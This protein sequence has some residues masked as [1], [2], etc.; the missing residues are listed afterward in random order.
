MAAPTPEQIQYQLQHIQDD[1]SDEIITALGICLAFAII[2]VLLR[3]VARHLT[4]APL[5]ADDWTILF[6]LVRSKPRCFHEQLPLFAGSLAEMRFSDLRHW[7]RDGP[8][9]L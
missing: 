6:G 5:G 3:F 2:T 7:P 1:R 8:S 9:C 4:G